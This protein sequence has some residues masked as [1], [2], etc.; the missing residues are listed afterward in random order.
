MPSG[1]P[2]DPGRATPRENSWN[3]FQTTGAAEPSVHIC[4]VFQY[5]INNCEQNVVLA[6][7]CRDIPL[8]FPLNERRKESTT[9]K[10][11]D[12]P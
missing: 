5:F 12:G 8:L 4:C 3:A 9:S 1:L 11:L 2:G 7:G 10:S 6:F